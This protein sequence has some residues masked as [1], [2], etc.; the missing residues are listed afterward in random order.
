MDGPG[1]D[2]LHPKFLCKVK[3]EIG[4]VLARIF[5]ESTMTGVVLRDW[6]HALVTLLFKKGNKSDRRNY[7]PTSLSCTL[8]KVMEKIVNKS[9]QSHLVHGKIINDSQ[10]GFT[11]GRSCLTNLL[12]FLEVY[13]KIRC[14]CTNEEMRANTN[15]VCTL[16][17][18]MNGLNDR[19]LIFVIGA[20]NR[21]NAIDDAL[22]RAGRFDEESF[23]RCQTSRLER[24][25]L[26]SWRQDG[27]ST[28]H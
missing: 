5:N 6:S 4:Q 21:L 26:P 10:H 13:D 24:I 18:L 16:L 28:A 7:R 9:L 22:R 27:T 12:D 1:L 14:T 19:N 8:G 11:R 3:E 20:T 2:K 25:F 17:G 23:F 15:V